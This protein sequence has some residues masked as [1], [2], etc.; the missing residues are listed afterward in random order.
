MRGVV[1]LAL[2]VTLVGTAPVSGQSPQP[3]PTPAAPAKPTPPQGSEAPRPQIALPVY[4]PP[5]RGAP[6]G[7]IGG[8]TRGV[9]GQSLAL[10][11][12]AP[13]D[14]ALTVS[15]Q[16][17]FYWY[18]SS[19][20]SLPVEVAIMDPGTVAPVLEVTLPGPTEAG[21]HA[22]RLADHG[23]R[24]RAGV[25]YRWYVAVVPDAGRR[26]RDVLAG[27]TVERIVP[28]PELA[29]SLT[30]AGSPER[31]S[32]YASAGLWYDALTALGE[33]IDRAPADPEP[34]RLRA[35]LLKQVGLPEVGAR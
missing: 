9:A 27:G 22:I 34:R 14:R 35:A 31:A 32:L 1:T 17:T 26:S 33:M 4:K 30:S 29:A 3:A 19:R 7:R 20:T 25:P 11:V 21:V 10:S 2:V 15:E 28:A 12:L 5:L 23:V 6:G 18:I 24:L 8:G 16:P 13:D